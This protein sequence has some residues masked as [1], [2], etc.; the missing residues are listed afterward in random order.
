VFLQF[1]S[2][3]QLLTSSLEWLRSELEVQPVRIVGSLFL[4]NKQLIA[5]QR[6]RPWNGVF[7]SEDYLSGPERAEAIHFC[8]RGTLYLWPI[9]CL[10]QFK[11]TF[12]V[13]AGHFPRDS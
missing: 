6:F 12:Q 10:T 5:Q 9:F 3:L 7:L 8:E 11:L 2:D 13:S 4:P 1:G